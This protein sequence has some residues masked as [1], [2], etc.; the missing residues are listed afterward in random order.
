MT[1]TAPATAANVT[2]TATSVT[3]ASQSASASIAITTSVAPTLPAGNY[4]FSLSGTDSTSDGA[5]PYYYAGAFT[6][7]QNGSGATVITTGEQDFSDFNDLTTAEPITGGTVTPTSDGNLLI[8]LNFTDT[9]INNGSG[10]VTFD[11]SLVSTSKALLIEYD[12]FGTASGELDLQA[13]TLSAPSGGYAFFTSGWALA[14]GT[15]TVYPFSW[16]GVLNVDGPNSISGNGSIFDMNNDATTTVLYPDETFAASS[17]TGPDSFGYVTFTLNPSGASTVPQVILDGYIVDANHIRLL[18]VFDSL[19]GITGGSAFGQGA[20]TGL[21][22]SASLSG[23]SYVA[24]ASGFDGNG[25]EQVAGILT[26]NS[27]G[28]VGGNISFNDLFSTNPPQGGATL[29]PESSPACSSGTATTPCYTIDGPGTGNDGGTGRVTMTNVTD[30]ATFSYDLQLYLTG[31]G[32]AVAISMDPNDAIA[33]LGWQQASGTFT[34]GAFSGSY[35]ADLVQLNSLGTE[36]DGV[37]ALFGDGVGT[38]SGFLDENFTLVSGTPTADNP[39]TSPYTTTSTNGVLDVTPAGGTTFLTYYV[40][41]N[42]QGVLI[43]NDTNLLT[44]GYLDLQQ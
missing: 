28:S 19:G 3:D 11:A 31:D 16:G 22:S 34:T 35:A 13:T 32:H 20:N 42:T 5:S 33:G 38:V 23:N 6:V 10:S 30:G 37:G 12:T 21:F 24:S 14:S 41:D 39:L 36:V 7:E 2:I 8:T 4:V 25:E 44:L 18:E 40:I 17:F 9:Y 15:S 43:E 29:E 1:Y 26:F 27:D